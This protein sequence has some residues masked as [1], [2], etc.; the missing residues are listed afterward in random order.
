MQE[1]ASASRQ[2]WA[3][4]GSEWQMGESAEAASNSWRTS[5]ASRDWWEDGGSAWQIFSWRTSSASRHW[6]EDGGSERQL[7]DSA[8]AR[9]Q[10]AVSASGQWWQDVA[11]ESAAARWQETASASGQSWQDVVSESQMGESASAQQEEAALSSWDLLWSRY[12]S[13]KIDVDAM[14]SMAA[15]STTPSKRE[16]NLRAAFRNYRR[17]IQRRLNKARLCKKMFGRWAAVSAHRQ[18]TLEELLWTDD[19]MMQFLSTQVTFEAYDEFHRKKKLE[20]RNP[21]DPHH[22]KRMPRKLP[23]CLIKLWQLNL[24]SAHSE[25]YW[26]NF[27]DMKVS[28]LTHTPFPLLLE[29]IGEEFKPTTLEASLSSPGLEHSTAEGKHTSLIEEL[30]NFTGSGLWSYLWHKA[31]DIILAYEVSRP[32]PWG[33]LSPS[34]RGRGWLVSRQLRVNHRSWG[35]AYYDWG[36][37]CLPGAAWLGNPINSSTP[38]SPPRAGNVQHL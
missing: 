24:A 18:P 15:R 37:C 22:N 28:R 30:R 31:A 27:D 25:A 36:I 11:S 4:G 23:P 34:T 3:D 29:Q 9:W 10:E 35:L 20:R 21:E 33:W 26:E 1:A 8:S 14:L 12:D 13:S 7:G 17:G 2:W 32:P 6:W 16:K 5:S 38:L 19:D